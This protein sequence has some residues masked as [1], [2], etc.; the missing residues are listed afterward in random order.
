MQ[1]IK[2]I[3]S[4]GDSYAFNSRTKCYGLYQISEICLRDFNQIQ[5]TNYVPGD[6]FNPLV[7]EMVASWYFKRVNKMLNFYEIPVSITTV[8]AS[9]NWGI[10]NVVKWYRNGAK[11]QD[12]PQETQRYIEKY[13]KINAE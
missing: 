11:F 10:G 2:T 13:Q 1:A 8:I 5:Q 9:Y 6:L 4:D 12:L 7:N 3:E